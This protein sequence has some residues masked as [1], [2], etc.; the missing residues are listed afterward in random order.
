MSVKAVLWVRY[1]AL[2]SMLPQMLEVFYCTNYENILQHW[3]AYQVLS[4]L[5]THKAT[6]RDDWSDAGK[7][8]END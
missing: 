8:E 1:C 6:E 3:T 2:V 5:L 4:G 7:V